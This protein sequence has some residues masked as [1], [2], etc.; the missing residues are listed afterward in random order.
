MCFM[1]FRLVDYYNKE[2][3]ERLAHFFSFPSSITDIRFYCAPKSLRPIPGIIDDKLSDTPKHISVY[4]LVHIEELVTVTIPLLLLQEIPNG[5]DAHIYIMLN[6]SDERTLHLIKKTME[7]VS[8]YQTE[9]KSN[10]TVEAI[11]L[12]FAG[13]AKTISYVREMNHA[14]EYPIFMDAD[15]ILHPAAIYS[16]HKFLYGT[17]PLSSSCEKFPVFNGLNIVSFADSYYVPG[18]SEHKLYGNFWSV[19]NL[20]FPKIPLIY[21]DD[22][23]IEKKTNSLH[24]EVAIVPNIWFLYVPCS[25]FKDYS[26]QLLR[27]QVGVD[28]I[29]EK[30][31]SL[32]PYCVDRSRW[33]RIGGMKG[34]LKM[35][36]VQSFTETCMMITQLILNLFITKVLG[37]K[38][39]TNPEQK[40][41]ST[42]LIR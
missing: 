11:K 15:V 39:V 2:E 16:F 24:E 26:K 41:A 29:I 4:M 6:G 10:I 1:R 9:H 20:R 17:K 30:D 18:S 37:K 42:N 34:F 19:S 27:R 8:Y 32:K 22:Y 31:P 33:Q 12:P 13:R 25:S 23:Y 14:N 21:R 7:L 35:F 3:L 38:Q 36:R 40:L 5:F 28:E